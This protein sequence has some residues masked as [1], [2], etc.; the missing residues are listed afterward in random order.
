[1]RIHVCVAMGMSVSLC[2]RA[3]S[4]QAILLG[5]LKIRI[6]FPDSRADPASFRKEHTGD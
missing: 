6:C 5:Q 2:G 3:N 4:L 1:M